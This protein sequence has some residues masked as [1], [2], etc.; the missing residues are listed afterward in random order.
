MLAVKTQYDNIEETL[1]VL[2]MSAFTPA[3]DRYLKSCRMN[4]VQGVR[5]YLTTIHCNPHWAYRGLQ[6][7]ADGLSVDALKIVCNYKK[8]IN[9]DH[10]AEWVRLSTDAVKRLITSRTTK[11]ETKEMLSC[12]LEVEP[13]PNFDT[14]ARDIGD[15]SSA[16]LLDVIL[17]HLS[18]SQKNIA[19][20]RACKRS[21]N[22][23]V[24]ERMLLEVDLNSVWP[25]IK[26]SWD[27]P[28]PE[29]VM[30]V[31]NFLLRNTLINE[32]EDVEKA[33]SRRKM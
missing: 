22:M 24:V 20:E 26:D 33:V 15:W 29:N 30:V 3:V 10:D 21:H 28:Y 2:T 4:N 8:K 13:K 6:Y 17:P 7:A 19:F 5:A 14:L 1:T 25:R 9:S 16:Q 23:D 18:N 27:K 11:S 31:E 12:L 32:L